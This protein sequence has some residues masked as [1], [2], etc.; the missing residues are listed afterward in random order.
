MDTKALVQ[1]AVCAVL[2]S[3]GSP[4]QGDDDDDDD[5]DDNDGLLIKVI[6]HYDKAHWRLASYSGEVVSSAGPVCIRW[7]CM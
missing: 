5:N 1:K 3:D 7:V 2:V 4:D 6:L